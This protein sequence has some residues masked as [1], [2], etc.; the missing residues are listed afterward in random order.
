[1]CYHVGYNIFYLWAIYASIVVITRSFGDK[2]TCYPDTMVQFTSEVSGYVKLSGYVNNYML[3]HYSWVSTIVFMFN[4]MI[5]YAFIFVVDY[6]RNVLL[7]ISSLLCCKI[8]LWTRDTAVQTKLWLS[9]RVQLLAEWSSSLCC[10]SQVHKASSNSL[11]SP[12]FITSCPYLLC[13]F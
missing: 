4:I 3:L 10:L 7:E 1:M 2:Q 5:C 8:L 6:E 12:N 13:S 9:F 11:Y